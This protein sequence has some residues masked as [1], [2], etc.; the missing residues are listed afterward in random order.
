MFLIS[1][2]ALMFC[3]SFRENCGLYMELQRSGKTIEIMDCGIEPMQ[4]RSTA[5]P[6]M[7]K[8]AALM[9]CAAEE[10]KKSRVRSNAPSVRLSAL[11]L[12]SQSRNPRIFSI[13]ISLF[14][15]KS[16]LGGAVESLFS[17]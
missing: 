2:G 15:C 8:Q 5:H 3:R 13:Y 17:S 11:R 14:S 16:T 7:P 9:R 4:V 12:T 6:P 10:M 1:F